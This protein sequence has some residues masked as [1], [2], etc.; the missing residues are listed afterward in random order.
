[1]PGNVV[2]VPVD[3]EDGSAGGS[4]AERLVRSGFELTSPAFVSWLGVTM[5]LTEAAIGQTFAELSGF[6]PGS[7][8][9]ADYM[10]PLTCETM[11]AVPTWTWSPPPQRSAVSRG[12]P[13]CRRRR[14]QHC[15]PSTA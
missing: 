6:V 5:Y 13:S 2:F 15:S 10:L 12:S 4:L 1:M 8:V 7:Q 11:T 3:F 14:C 9:V